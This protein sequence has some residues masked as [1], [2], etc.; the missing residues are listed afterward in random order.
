MEPLSC[1][2]CCHNP[3]QLGALGTS[4]GFCT[5]HRSL[6]P[7]S[8]LT[9]CGQL[10]RKDLLAQ[11]ARE[12]GRIHRQSYR[13]GKI[14]VVGEPRRAAKD[15]GLVEV[16]NGQVPHDDVIDDVIDYGRLETKVASLAVL[17]ARPGTRAEVAMLSLGR[18]YFENC[19]SRG[20]KWTAGLHLAER[21]LRRLEKLPGIEATDLRG[22]VSAPLAKLV[23]GAQWSVVA[24]RLALLHD[25]GT[26]AGPQDPV[27]AWVDLVGQAVANSAAGSGTSLLAVVHRHRRAFASALPRA[28]Y[29]ELAT[30]L[31]KG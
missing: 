25:I 22:P 11:R 24:Q 29:E 20:G 6:L 15:A 30:E 31:H 23:A 14:V 16:A 19:R 27:F 28:R 18:G 10:L 26:A 4:F 3:L 21:V 7:A 8:N 17:W 1:A 2:N 13:P 9:T 5:K 12:Q